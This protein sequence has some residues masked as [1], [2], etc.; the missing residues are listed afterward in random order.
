MIGSRRISILSTSTRVILSI[1]SARTSPIVEAPDDGRQ[2]K[3]AKRILTEFGIP[4]VRIDDRLFL[5]LKVGPHEGEK[6]RLIG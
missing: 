5:E 6:E 4:D 2:I 1:T 3:V